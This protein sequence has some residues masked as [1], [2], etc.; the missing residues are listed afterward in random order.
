MPSWKFNRLISHL[1]A[2]TF[3]TR[4]NLRAIHTWY[5]IPPLNFQ[6]KQKM[7]HLSSLQ[8]L[9]LSTSNI[10][11]GCTAH[12]PTQPNPY[13]FPVAVSGTSIDV[14]YYYV[15]WTDNGS[16]LPEANTQRQ[17]EKYPT[18]KVLQVCI[19]KSLLHS[20]NSVPIL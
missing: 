9:L 19:L 1:G 3:S 18:I 13:R 12:N 17:E 6:C 14:L 4:L 5:N 20:V 8:H 16:M 11:R 15:I 10:S 7:P 2:K